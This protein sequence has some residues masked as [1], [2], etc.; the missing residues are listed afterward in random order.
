MQSEDDDVI[1]REAKR[2]GLVVYTRDSD[3][4]RLHAKQIPHGGIIYN[5]PL[6]YSIGETIRRL[7]VVCETHE[8]DEIENRVEYL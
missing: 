8:R 2:R 4:L 3:F 7:M 6:T 5:H 1:L